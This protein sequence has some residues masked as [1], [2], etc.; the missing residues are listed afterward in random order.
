MLP[1]GAHMALK[2][3]QV[4]FGGAGKV[5]FRRVYPRF[6]GVEL[7]GCVDRDPELRR[8]LEA[9]PEFA[10]ERWFASLAEA[11]EA[12]EADA[13]SV[14]A[15][16]E[17]HAPL[18]REALEAGKHVIVEKPFT[19]RVAEARDL[20]ELAARM[21]RRL[22]VGQNYR[23]FP[24]P[25]TVL[26]LLDE[27]RLGPIGAVRI[28]FRHDVGFSRGADSK[29]AQLD[30]PLLV[31]MA[32]HHFDLLRMLLRREPEAVHCTTFNPP[33]SEYRD[34]PAAFATVSFPSSAGT[35]DARTPRARSHVVVSYRGSWVSHNEPTPWSGLWEIECEQGSI[36][37]QGRIKAED[38][39][40]D[41]V[42]IRRHD[43]SVEDVPLVRLPHV[44]RAGVFHAFIDAVE[45]GNDAECSGHD[46]IGTIAFMNAMIESAEN[47]T[48]VTPAH[49]SPGA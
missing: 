25:R 9:D 44:D 28:D 3:V 46:N 41:R 22:V 45:A 42:M 43:G 14:A 36:V 48:V 27:G 18:V 20:A 1:L 8:E 32:V 17:G 40:A 24:A 39:S 10:G 2:L 23:F 37:W 26:S 35:P 30:H 4:G 7:V 11:L 6:E 29:H 47:G 19:R 16:L 33:W 12:V 13:V 31:D 38:V 5:W 34:P 21:D 15:H 49:V